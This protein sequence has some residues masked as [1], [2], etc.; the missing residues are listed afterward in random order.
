M[1]TKFWWGNMKERYHFESLGVD[2]KQKYIGAVGCIYLVQN[3]D[4]WQAFVHMVLKL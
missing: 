3:E 1:H 2:W 4:K